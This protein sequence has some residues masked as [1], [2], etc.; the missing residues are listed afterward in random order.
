[1]IS[2]GIIRQK[3]EKTHSLQLPVEN[4]AP[5]LEVSLKTSR[6]KS[7]MKIDANNKYVFITSNNVLEEA[8]FIYRISPPVLP[9]QFGPRTEQTP[10][11]RQG[12]FLQFE[13]SQ[14]MNGVFVALLL[15]DVMLLYTRKITYIF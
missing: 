8:I 11:L 5:F 15:R 1:M 13:S 12:T 9:I 14:K 2:S 10:I 7:T 3:L 6:N 4:L